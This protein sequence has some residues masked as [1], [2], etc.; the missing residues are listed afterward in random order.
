MTI[1]VIDRI[2]EF[3]KLSTINPTDQVGHLLSSAAVV[4]KMM[5]RSADNN[6]A[7]LWRTM[8]TFYLSSARL[9]LI[10]ADV[11]VRSN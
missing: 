8:P 3:I 10:A 1:I 9:N 2:K 6:D 5:L 4:S 7:S 11:T